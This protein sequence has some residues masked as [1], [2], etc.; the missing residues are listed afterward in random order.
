MSQSSRKR[1]LSQSERKLAYDAAHRFFNVKGVYG[2]PDAIELARL[3]IVNALESLASSETAATKST[4]N[5][6]NFIQ[7][8][9]NIS[10]ERR[11]GYERR[12]HGDLVNKRCADDLE[13]LCQEYLSRSGERQG[14]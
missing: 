13:T 8:A 12:E 2:G 7:A 9:L 10:A 5:P 1:E 11:K 4:M 3:A 14:G 6:E